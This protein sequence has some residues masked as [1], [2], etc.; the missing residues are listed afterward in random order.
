MV[1]K[2]AVMMQH[3][4]GPFVTRMVCNCFLY[5]PLTNSKLQLKLSLRSQKVVHR[6]HPP[7]AH[8]LAAINSQPASSTKRAH[9][10]LYLPQHCQ[11]QMYGTQ[12]ATLQYRAAHAML[13]DITC[14]MHMYALFHKDSVR[15]YLY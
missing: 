5:Y 3:S 13:S 15:Y 11:H 10:A 8:N 6:Q 9:C 2:H 1:F 4:A 12:H 14:H 7:N